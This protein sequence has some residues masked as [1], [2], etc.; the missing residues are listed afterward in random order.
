MNKL[1]GAVMRVAGYGRVST[2]EQALKGTS[3]EEQRAIIEKQCE[4]QGHELYKFYSDDGFS[5]RN[6]NRPGLQK[7]M[8]DAKDGKFDL[9]HF[10]K[11]RQIRKKS[12]RYKK[13]S[14]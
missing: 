12:Q 4:A 7:L 9:G 10:Y 5:G 1:K 13:Y 3:P 6:D 8:S 11:A 2:A 14:L